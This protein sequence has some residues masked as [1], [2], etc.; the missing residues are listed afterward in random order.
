MS[1]KRCELNVWQRRIMV[2]EAF[3]VGIFPDTER[4]LADAKEDA[5]RRLRFSTPNV[6]ITRVCRES[7]REFVNKNIAVCRARRGKAVCRK[8]SKKQE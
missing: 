3:V 2:H 1:M 4:G 5:A 6:Y 8:P 7:G